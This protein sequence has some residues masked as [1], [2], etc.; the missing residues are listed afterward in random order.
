[1]SPVRFLAFER[2]C[3]MEVEDREMIE[4]L[5]GSDKALRRLVRVVTA[6]GSEPSEELELELKRARRQLR[7]NRELIRPDAGEAG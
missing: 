6:D 5:E 1:M 3:A 7:T 4:A 2:N